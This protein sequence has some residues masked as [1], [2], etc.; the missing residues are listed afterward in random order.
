MGS[1]P[2]ETPK[3]IRIIA[4]A[5]ASLMLCVGLYFEGALFGLAA[6]ASLWKRTRWRDCV[7][8]TAYLVIS[9]LLF[10]AGRHV[11][12]CLAAAIAVVGLVCSFWPRRSRGAPLAPEGT[13]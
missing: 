8:G 3:V 9:A 13:E 12:A 7:V 10:L 4:L 1:K 6:L 11:A 2:P 5:V